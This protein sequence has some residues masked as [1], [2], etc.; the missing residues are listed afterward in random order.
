MNPIMS[1]KKFELKLE[2]LSQ[3]ATTIITTEGV[4]V[5]HVDARDQHRVHHVVCVCV[6]VTVCVSL[7]VCM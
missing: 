1:I 5:F 6:C 4:S 2:S 7:C 3:C